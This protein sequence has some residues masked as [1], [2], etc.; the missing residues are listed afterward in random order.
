MRQ[1]T[2]PK[3]TSEPKKWYLVDVKDAVLGRIASRIASKLLGK[4]NPSY[5]TYANDGDG[6]IVINAK[7]IQVTG[8]KLEE[9]FYWHTG[10]P[11]GIKS[12]TIKQRLESEFPERVLMKAVE[13]MLGRG[14]LGRAQLRNLRIYAEAE[15][16]HAGQNPEIWNL[17]E[18][19]KKNK[20]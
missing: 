11:G 4:E 17:A 3:G 9:P 18:E 7:Y 8:N 16:P 12:R 19:H 13:R 10:H 14:P 5:T 20:K 15:H 1:T 6:V 2:F